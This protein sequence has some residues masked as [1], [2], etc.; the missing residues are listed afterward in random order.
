MQLRLRTASV[1]AIVALAGS[2]ALAPAALTTATAS[3][4]APDRAGVTAECASAQI[5]LA[6][7]R[8]S[9]AK[10]H[11][12]VVKARK[13]V[14]K[15]KHAHQAAKVRKAKKVLKR[16]RHRYAVRS[17]N[18]D[19]Q[20]SR[21][22]YACSSP[23]S[24][25][26]A[27]GTGQQLN[28]IAL[29]SGLTGGAIDLSQLTALLDRLLPGVA[30]HL[31]AGQLSALLGGFNSGPVSLDEATIL[32]GSVFSP[33]E[34]AALLGG[35]ASP[36]LVLA[37]AQHVI[38]QL[39]GLGGGLPIPGTFDPAALLDTFAGIFGS[40]DPTQLGG[41]VDL[42]LAGIGKP[43]QTLADTTKLASLLDGLQPG[44]SSKFSPS[45]LTAMLAAVNGPS[46]GADG[47]SNLLG[48]AFDPAD[49]T[50]VLGASGGDQLIG[51]VL[52]NVVGQLGAFGTG[53]VVVPS[54]DPSQLTTLV[55]TVTDLVTAVLGGGVIQTV[56]TLLPIFC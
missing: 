39:S 21:V 27:A 5:A 46:L 26:R 45:D 8:S 16:W 55:S 47:L 4:V 40:L 3:P 54:L 49:L 28:L 36:D 18:V 9:Q 51:E 35:S 7:A 41:L 23:T 1:A 44:L 25:A 15:A 22:G 56:C 12:K 33:E 31:D 6:S 48:G 37:L 32:L 42:L 50:S 2:L 29:A 17:H 13:A 19:V 14:R 38:G 24:A 43:D 20:T 10:A 34:L 53:D 11:K 30:S 52:A